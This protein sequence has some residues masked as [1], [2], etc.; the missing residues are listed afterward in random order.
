M[1]WSGDWA[2][3]TPPWIAFD[4]SFTQVDGTFNGSVTGGVTPGASMTLNFIGTFQFQYLFR[5]GT[6]RF[7]YS[8]FSGTSVDVYGVSIASSAPPASYTIDDSIPFNVSMPENTG[9]P[10]PAFN[11]HYISA[12]LSS[13]G[14]HTLVITCEIANSFYIDYVLVGSDTAFVPPPTAVEKRGG[15]PTASPSS[16]TGKQQNKSGVIVGSVVGTASLVVVLV[17]GVFLWRCRRRSR[18]RH[19]NGQSVQDDEFPDRRT[20]RTIDALYLQYTD[21]ICHVSYDE[22][23][24]SVLS[25]PPYGIVHES[26]KGYSTGRRRS[27]RV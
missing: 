4:D 24:H 12:P 18:R 13:V 17:L 2:V 14:N 16:S 27:I 23:G 6:S 1:S 22:L 3:A 26:A 9:D 15:T 25:R 7:E 5:W 19:V 21:E 11:W 20:Y 8:T 10:S